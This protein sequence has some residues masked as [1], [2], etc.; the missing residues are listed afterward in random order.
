MPISMYETRKMLE[1]LQ[2]RLEPTMFLKKMFFSNTVQFETKVVDIDIWKGQ[3]RIAP[4]VSSKVKGKL[5]ERIGFTTHSYEPPYIK[6]KSLATADDGMDR[7]PGETV[8]SSNG[9]PEERVRKLLAGD[10]VDMEEQI[11]RREELMCADVLDDGI[12]TVVGE[13]IELTIDF[14]MPSDNKITLTGPALWSALSTANPY[15]DLRKWKRQIAQKTGR[16]ADVVVL[17]QDVI[18]N[19]LNNAIIKEK[20]ALYNQNYGRL[21]PK[22]L[23][24]GVTH[25]ITFPEFGLSV[26]SYDGLYLD[27]DTSIEKSYM[28]RHKVWMGCTSA[29][30]NFSYGAIKDLKAGTFAVSRFPKSWEEED[31]SVRYLL[32][33]S[34]PLP[35]LQQS[36][37][38]ISAYVQDPV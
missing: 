17:G 29:R 20:V 38:F 3:R 15:N 23:P 2:Q 34:A 12:L 16:N 21:D 8:Y 14:L 33:Q 18:E 24:E 4:F 31:P 5:V 32:L 1:M 36:D 35:Q 28:P 13:G 10:L 11:L 30:T 37:C 22:M 7:L 25:Y 19:F 27:L 9:G 6:I 26:Y